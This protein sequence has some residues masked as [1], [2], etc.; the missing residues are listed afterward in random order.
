[1]IKKVIMPA[2]LF[3]GAGV[4]EKRRTSCPMKN[5]KVSRGRISS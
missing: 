4:S 3:C 1:M 2:A 5:L